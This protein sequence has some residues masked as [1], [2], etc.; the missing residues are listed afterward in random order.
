M[1]KLNETKS[2]YEINYTEDEHGASW[3]DVYYATQ[4]DS[5]NGWILDDDGY[6]VVECSSGRA[7]DG[8]LC[9]NTIENFCEQFDTFEE[10]LEYAE[11]GA[12]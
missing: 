8:G 2:A 1:S 6:V 4:G 7:S 5:I 10:A 9:W 3:R 11:G 12:Q